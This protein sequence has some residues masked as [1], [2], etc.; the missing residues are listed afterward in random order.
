MHVQAAEP[1]APGSI[2]CLIADDDRVSRMPLVTHLLQ[3]GY[4]V[5]EANHGGEAL[6]LYARHQPDVVLMDVMMPVMDGYEATRALRA[7]NGG[8]FTPVIFLTAFSEQSV[9]RRCIEAGGEDF[10][11]KPADPALV[12]FKIRGLLRSRHLYDTLAQQTELVKTYAEE[13]RQEQEVA[14]CVFRKLIHRGALSD[15]CFRYLISPSALF[16]GDLLF[17]A[18]RPQGGYRVLLGDFTGH[19]LPAAIGALP[20]SEIFYSMTAKGCALPDLVLEMNRKLKLVLPPG[21]FCAAELLD[22][23]A[24]WTQLTIWSAGV[25]DTSILGQ[26]GSLRVIEGGNLPLGITDNANYKLRVMQVDLAPTDRIYLHS[27]GINEATNA[28]GEMFGA[29]QITACLRAHAAND[30]FAALLG[31]LEIFRGRADQAD[32]MTLLEMCGAGSVPA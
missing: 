14:E 15:R 2:I 21:L 4:R 29:A 12:E 32:D 24:D 7:C 30:A 6:D 13:M 25:P 5:L 10:V 8:H 26:D 23:D 20:L 1:G 27:D 17:A 11:S 18:R 9:L 19:G 16:N 31:E 28:A 3:L 22:V